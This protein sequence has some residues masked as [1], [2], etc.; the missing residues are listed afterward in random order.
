VE[1]VTGTER[2]AIA[3]QESVKRYTTLSWGIVIAALAIIMILAQFIP[4]LALVTRYLAATKRLRI[5]SLAL[6][7]AT[8]F[9]TFFKTAVAPQASE[10]ATSSLKMVLR[11]AREREVKA[12]K[13]QLAADA[14]RTFVE[15]L[16]SEQRIEVHDTVVS[17]NKVCGRNEPLHRKTLQ[18]LLND[19]PMPPRNPLIDARFNEPAAPVVPPQ[20]IVRAVHSALPAAREAEQRALQM[21]KRR[22]QAR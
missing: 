10:T 13:R 1:R 5:A 21:E 4:R 2:F 14:V 7:A 11:Q 18:G 15:T 3:A 6:T 20:K 16:T 22:S 9:I 17:I 8:A 19:A 12:L